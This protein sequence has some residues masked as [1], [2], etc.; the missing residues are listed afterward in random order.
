MPDGAFAK[1]CT[2]LKLIVKDGEGHIDV[3]PPSMQ[4]IWGLPVS[5]CSSERTW[6]AT[7]RRR[8][9]SSRQA[10]RKPE[11]VSQG[12]TQVAG[13]YDA[14]AAP[15]LGG[16]LAHVARELVELAPKTRVLEIG[17]GPGRLAVQLAELGPDVRVIGV[18]V[19][20]EMVER[21]NALA[22]RSDVGDRV[23]FRAGDVSSLPFADAS[24]DIV[25][26]TFS[27]HH[28]PDPLTAPLARPRGWPVGDLPRASPGRPGQD[29]RHGR[30]DPE[31]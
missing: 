27:L 1:S 8:S 19:S 16:F 31:A 6:R 29:L 20:P 22:V 5:L 11:P 7:L 14:L 4:Y 24:F 26:S 10:P 30:L 3:S 28:W 25:V 9:R 23:E 2:K 13:L 18:D 21:E 12:D 17:S 15:V